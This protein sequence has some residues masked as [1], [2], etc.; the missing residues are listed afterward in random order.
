MSLEMERK[1]HTLK[2]T[3]N[4]LDRKSIKYKE[5]RKQVFLR[6]NFTCQECKSKKDIHPHHIKP[7][8]QY[9]DLRFVISNGITLCSKCHGKI[10][11]INFSKTGHF[12]ICKICQI[13]FRPKSGYLK[14]QTCSKKCGYELRNQSPNK[15]KGKHYPHLQRSETRICLN[16]GKSFRGIKDFKN[17]KQKYCSHA[18]YLKKRWNFTNK[19][20]KKV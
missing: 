11:G 15:K 8:A 18:C 16:C 20:A 7:F 12:I 17:R 3:K 9:R 14:Q 2:S 13:R 6:D 4:E 10:H 5:W 1:F 19:K